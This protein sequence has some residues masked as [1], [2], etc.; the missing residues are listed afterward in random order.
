MGGALWGIGY[1]VWSSGNITHEVI[2]QYLE[3]YKE[4]PNIDKNLFWSDGNI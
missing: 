1:G 3:R 2:Q 4:R